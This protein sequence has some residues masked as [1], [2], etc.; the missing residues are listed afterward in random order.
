MEVGEGVGMDVGDGVAVGAG[1]EASTGVFV[2]VAVGNDIT[3]DVD[4]GF[5]EIVAGLD[6]DESNAGKAK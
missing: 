1:F 4:K 5:C 6:F 2:G 3:V